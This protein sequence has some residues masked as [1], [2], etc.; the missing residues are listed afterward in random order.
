MPTCLAVLA[1]PLSSSDWSIVLELTLMCLNVEILLTRHKNVMYICEVLQKMQV[2]NGHALLQTCVYIENQ[3]KS[4][5][6]SNLICSYCTLKRNGSLQNQKWF[7]YL[8]MECQ[9]VSIQSHFH[10]Q[11][12]PYLVPLLTPVA[13]A[14]KLQFS[15]F[16]HCSI[17]ICG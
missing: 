10:W 11:Q 13:Y 3:W 8:L 12:Y 15:H 4:S 14:R 17:N 16:Y 2:Y 9:K 7:H 6:L 5:T 1:L